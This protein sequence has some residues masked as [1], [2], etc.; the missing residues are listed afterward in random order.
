M[1]LST[2]TGI[3]KCNFGEVQHVLIFLKS[4]I[5]YRKGVQCHFYQRIF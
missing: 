4:C 5:E 3:K 2:G 1:V